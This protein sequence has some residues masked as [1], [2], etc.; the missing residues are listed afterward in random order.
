MS[1]LHARYSSS[2]AD[3]D[4]TAWDDLAQ[5]WESPFQE[6]AWLELLESSGSAVAEA[7]WLPRHLTLWDGPE[8]V[9]AAPL[10]LKT[11]SEGEFVFDHPIADLAGRLGLEYYPKL[12]GMSP[13]TPTGRYGVL[14]RSGRDARSLSAAV[15]SAVDD[16]VRGLS[17]SGSHFHF[18]HPRLANALEPLGYIA[19]E[20]HSFEWRRDGAGSFDEFLERFSRNQ[21]RNILKERRALAR[22]GV[23]VR[24][25]TGGD[26][27]ESVMAA[28]YDYYVA[29]NA[30]FGVW[31]CKWL[32]RE[33]FLRLPEVFAGRLAIV[34]AYQDGLG[35]VGMAL[36]IYKQGR[37][38]GR[39]WGGR[40]IPFLHFEVCYYTPIEWA[41]GNRLDVFDPGIGG[42][43]K[44]R[45][46]FEA[47]SNV[48][49]HKF[50]DPRMRMV[51][52]RY[53]PDINAD[54]SAELAEMNEL[55]P[56]KNAPPVKN[57]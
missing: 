45:R 41:I 31:A 25:L 47:V 3:I 30:K 18:V 28:M 7:G 44:V 20:H 12:I 51:M 10:Y 42:Y 24:V 33:F 8:L 39:Y 36:L 38:Y 34:A 46:G 5:P 27:T 4:Q 19:W 13:F 53:M 56:L 49:L 23:D 21:R 15:A 1:I 29:T 52:Q 50:A 48:S 40:D 6:W 43:H 35:P 9:A 57:P 54:V 32:T 37:L 14:L 17:L 22:E 16:Q 2:M 55:R 26:V 11:H